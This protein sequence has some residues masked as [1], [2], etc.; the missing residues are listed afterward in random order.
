MGIAS[1]AARIYFAKFSAGAGGIFLRPI[2]A[3]ARASRLALTSPK[4]FLL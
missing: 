2:C 1:G 3:A 4:R